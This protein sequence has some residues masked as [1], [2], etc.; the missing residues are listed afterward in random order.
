MSRF[1]PRVTMYVCGSI[2]ACCACRTASSSRP[3]VIWRPPPSTSVSLSTQSPGDLPVS[4]ASTTRCN[5]VRKCGR[6]NSMTRNRVAPNATRVAVIAAT[7]RRNTSPASTPSPSAYNAYAGTTRPSMSKLLGPIR[8]SSVS[9]GLRHHMTTT[10]ATAPARSVPAASS[11]VFERRRRRRERRGDR[12]RR[13]AAT[14]A[15][16]TLPMPSQRDL[17]RLTRGGQALRRHVGEQEVLEADGLDRPRRV[18]DRTLDDREQRQLPP[19]VPLPDD[20]PDAPD[21]T[22]RATRA[23]EQAMRVEQRLDVAL[24]AHPA[25]GEQ[26]DVVA[27][28][29]DVRDDVRRDDDGRPGLGDAVHQQLQ[30]LAPGE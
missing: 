7:V 11:A 5:G 18:D 14:G 19:A 3:A 16:A 9:Y 23:G 2:R 22:Q 17:L 10:L 26:H 8:P 1:Q 12:P 20:L 24:E 21:R 25:A 6:M 4:V 28:A 15:D 30:E 27:D 29:L 13:R